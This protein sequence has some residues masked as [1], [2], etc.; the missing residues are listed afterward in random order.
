MRVTLD[1]DR[2]VIDAAK[3]IASARSIPLG[4]AV[5]LLARRGLA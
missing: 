1:L 4:A 3:A 5:S 2:D